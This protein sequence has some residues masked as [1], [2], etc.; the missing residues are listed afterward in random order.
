MNNQPPH[1]GYPKVTCLCDCHW[2]AKVY[3][4][5]D[6]ACEHCKPSKA[7]LAIWPYYKS[8]NESD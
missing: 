6:Y 1:L 8:G 4:L 3:N 5:P 7:I 2:Y